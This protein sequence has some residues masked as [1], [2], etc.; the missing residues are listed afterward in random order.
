L[1]RIAPDVP[2]LSRIDLNRQ[3]GMEKEKPRKSGVLLADPTRFERVTF[4]FG[5]QRFAKLPD[6]G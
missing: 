6:A 4:A 5:G 1:A 3:H 2:G